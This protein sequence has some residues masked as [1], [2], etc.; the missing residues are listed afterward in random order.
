MPIQYSNYNF[1]HEA[2]LYEDV[3]KNS[4]TAKHPFYIKALVPLETE[5]KKPITINRSNIANKSQEGLSTYI[6][7]SNMTMDL[8]L[9]MYLLTD[10]PDDV[11]PKGTKFLV[12]FVGGNINNCQIIGRCYE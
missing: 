3:P 6:M 7:T 10:Y 11:V 8:F 2:L 12:G 1:V 5:E 4:K 9:P